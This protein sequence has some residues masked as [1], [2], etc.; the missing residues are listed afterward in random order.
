VQT[1]NSQISIG[2]PKAGVYCAVFPSLFY[3]FFLVPEASV[4]EIDFFESFSRAV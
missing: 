3:F 2:L 4:Y 1:Q